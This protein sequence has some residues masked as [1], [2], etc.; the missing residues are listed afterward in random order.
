MGEM[1]RS[2]PFV[3]PKFTS[4]LNTGAEGVEEISSCPRES[5]W[6]AARSA[7]PNRIVA[8][9][10][11]TTRLQDGN[12]LWLLIDVSS[13]VLEWAR[14][15]KVKSRFRD[16][17]TGDEQKERCPQNAGR[18]MFRD[19]GHVNLQIIALVRRV[20]GAQDCWRNIPWLLKHSYPG[21]CSKKLCA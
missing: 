5:V 21:K 12:F 6:A 13:F 17:V 11:T 4:V 18:I 1:L 20:G 16:Y 19:G 2:V 3:P 14:T 9:K 7:P 10:A 15:F 8:T